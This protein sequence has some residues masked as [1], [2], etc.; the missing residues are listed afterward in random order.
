MPSAPSASAPR[1]VWRPYAMLL[2]GATMVALSPIFV[3]LSELEPTA[4]GVWRTA[5]SLPL[6]FAWMAWAQGRNPAPRCLG[7]WR[8]LWPLVLPGLLF[9]GDL[10]FWHW[11]I[12]FTSVANATLFANFAPLFVALGA[13]LI[14]GQKIGGRLWLGI[15]IA[16]VGA[17]V[18]LGESLSLNAGQALGDALGV[19]TAVFF[20]SYV[21]AVSRLRDR[22]DSATLMFY[23]SLVTCATL[24]VIAVAMG[25]SLWPRTWMGWL[26][27]LAL[28]WATQVLGQ[29]L[30]AASLGHIAPAFA[31]LL[32][33][34]EPVAAAFFGWAFLG[35]GL[36]LWQVGGGTLMLAG[37][38]LARREG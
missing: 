16:L 26:N 8:A 9:A 14:L 7:E 24:V 29:G 4:T 38:A 10:F 33:L 34:T 15:A 12:Y 11:S 19:A 3:R 17:G 23:S 13:W 18:M 27:L 32:I 22:Y 30:I 5:L 20:G 37:V 28:A 35:E 1:A 36:S 21:L 2:G 31:A 6:L 25:E